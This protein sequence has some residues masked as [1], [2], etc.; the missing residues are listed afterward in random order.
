MPGLRGLKGTGRR[1]RRIA[2]RM[3]YSPETESFGRIYPIGFDLTDP[4]RATLAQIGKRLG[5]EALHQVAGV[6]RPDTILGWYRKLIAQK[7]DGSKYRR[8]PGRPAIGRE[9]TDSPSV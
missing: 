1:V 5:R 7:F 8:Y 2:A 4:Q 6:A 3:L 9:I